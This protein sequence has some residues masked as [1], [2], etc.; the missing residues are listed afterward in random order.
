M[1][2]GDDPRRYR[3]QVIHGRLALAVQTNGDCVH[4]RDGKCTVYNRAPK[5]CR[6]FICTDYDRAY[7][8][9]IGQ[10]A[11]RISLGLLGKEYYED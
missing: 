11:R 3:L 9:A 10:A 1:E 7:D 5:I 6:D 2:P 8:T 4:L